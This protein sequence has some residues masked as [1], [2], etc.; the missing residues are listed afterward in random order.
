M[1]YTPVSREV[2][3]SNSNSSD[4][5]TDFPLIELGNRESISSSKSFLLKAGHNQVRVIEL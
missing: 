5:L 4:D 1:H 3:M 2:D